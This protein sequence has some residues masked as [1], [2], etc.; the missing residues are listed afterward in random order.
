MNAEVNNYNKVV[1]M[2]EKKFSSIHEG[3]MKNTQTLQKSQS[4]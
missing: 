1:G 4:I 3:L 2:L